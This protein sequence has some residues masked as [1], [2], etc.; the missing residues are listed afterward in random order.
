ML[1]KAI[2]A[3]CLTLRYSRRRYSCI[4]KRI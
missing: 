2:A 3:A 4:E 1:N